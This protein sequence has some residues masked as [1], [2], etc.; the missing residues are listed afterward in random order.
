MPD[1]PKSWRHAA[2]E[3]EHGI[4]ED[5]YCGLSPEAMSRAIVAYHGGPP[6]PGEPVGYDPSAA[7]ETRLGWL[8]EAFGPDADV[9]RIRIQE[10]FFSARVDEL[11]NLDWK[12]PAAEFDRAVEEGLVRHAPDLTEEARRVI[13]GNYSYS[14]W[15]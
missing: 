11:L 12:L 4:P 8:H 5:F 6:R 2:L 3:R 1:D 7:P 10:Q 9:E 15:K 14:H 13:A